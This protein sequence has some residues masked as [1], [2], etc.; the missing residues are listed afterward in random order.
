LLLYPNRIFF[1]P[2]ASTHGGSNIDHQRNVNDAINQPTRAGQ[3]PSRAE[4]DPC[5]FPH[6]FRELNDLMD[7]KSAAA[8]NSTAESAPRNTTSDPDPLQKLEEPRMI[9]DF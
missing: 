9:G 2:F 3:C 4:A 1:C 7:T 6:N 5:V 8:N